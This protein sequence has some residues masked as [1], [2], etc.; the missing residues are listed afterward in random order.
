MD[1]MFHARTFR[2]MGVP[3]FLWLTFAFGLPRRII[4]IE[5]NAWPTLPGGTLHFEGACLTGGLRKLDGHFAFGVLL[6]PC[7]DGKRGALRACH[8]PGLPVDGKI[9]FAK[10]SRCFCQLVLSPV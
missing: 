5:R 8:R 7:R 10:T 2:I 3:R 6:R 1:R 4:R 9:R